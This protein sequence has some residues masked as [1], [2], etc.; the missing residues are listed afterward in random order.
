MREVLLKA[1]K[2]CQYF[3]IKKLSFYSSL[4]IGVSFE[5]YNAVTLEWPKCPSNMSNVQSTQGKIVKVR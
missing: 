2:I 5:L 4:D 1:A 3:R